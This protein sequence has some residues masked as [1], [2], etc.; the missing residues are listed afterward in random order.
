MKLIA[1][2]FLQTNATLEQSGRSFSTVS[3]ELR[4]RMVSSLWPQP[5]TV[6][7]KVEQN[8]LSGCG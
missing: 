7:L 8:Q 2:T 4:R 5:T 6:R 3:T 1:V